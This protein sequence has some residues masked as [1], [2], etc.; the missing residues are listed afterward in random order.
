VKVIWVL[1]SEMKLLTKLPQ[2]EIFSALFAVVIGNP[3]PV[4]VPKTS[5]YGPAIS[6]WKLV[7]EIDT[8]RF[9]S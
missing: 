3:E 7:S 9:V 4:I 8:V 6:G 5:P 1:V 2:S